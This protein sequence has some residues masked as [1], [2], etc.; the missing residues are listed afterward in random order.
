M[1]F[2]R[3]YWETSRSLDPEPDMYIEQQQQNQKSEGMG[4]RGE[5]VVGSAGNC[6]ALFAVCRMLLR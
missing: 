4:G 5:P 3:D 6:A 2:R 1:L